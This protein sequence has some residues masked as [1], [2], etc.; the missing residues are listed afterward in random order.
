MVVQLMTC[1]MGHNSIEWSKKEHTIRQVIGVVILNQLIHSHIPLG[2]R[3]EFL[4]T[5]H[6]ARSHGLLDLFGLR[7]VLEL[8]LV[9]GTEGLVSWQFIEVGELGAVE[10]C[11]SGPGWRLRLQAELV[12][13]SEKCTSVTNASVD[14]VWSVLFS[15]PLLP[16]AFVNLDWF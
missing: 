5:E 15:I 4:P 9:D 12:V 6:L 1:Q 8:R 14:S 16:K 11:L 7:V 2:E 3:K 10:F 13:C